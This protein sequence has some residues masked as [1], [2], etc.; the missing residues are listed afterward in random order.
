MA[1]I[2]VRSMTEHTCWEGLDLVF[3]NTVDVWTKRGHQCRLI[4]DVKFHG[5]SM[6]KSYD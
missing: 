5:S 6:A 3:R 1:P 2:E 4:S